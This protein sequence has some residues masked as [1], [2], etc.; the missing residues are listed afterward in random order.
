[1]GTQAGRVVEEE[2]LDK[3]M[4]P[5]HLFAFLILAA[6]SL[7]TVSACCCSC[8]SSCSCNIFCCECSTHDGGYCYW[9]GEYSDSG[10]CYARNYELQC[11][12]HKASFQWMGPQQGWPDICGR[13]AG[14]R[15]PDSHRILDGRQGPEWLCVPL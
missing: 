15:K 7:S 10:P 3:R 5:T 13:G 2:Q 8:F 11:V 4:K 12:S 9:D 14:V 6:A 1:M